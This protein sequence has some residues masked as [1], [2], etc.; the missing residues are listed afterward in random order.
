MP[1]GMYKIVHIG[2]VFLPL[3]RR[4]DA[5]SFHFTVSRS[6]IDASCNANTQSVSSIRRLSLYVAQCSAAPPEFRTVAPARHVSLMYAAAP[7]RY[8]SIDSYAASISSAV[9]PMYFAVS[10][11][12]EWLSIDI[13][14]ETSTPFSYRRYPN[15]LRSECVPMQPIFS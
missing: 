7:C 15:V 2:P 14:R 3:V 11:S 1:V 10:R 5:T 9:I 4:V 12:L 13:M 8:T 6:D